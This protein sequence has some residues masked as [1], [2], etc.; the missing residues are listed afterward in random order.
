MHFLV[1]SLAPLEVLVNE[2][3]LG[4]PVSGGTG[5]GVRDLGAP[6]GQTVL[7]ARVELKG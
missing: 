6:E 3:P 2:L 5:L 7:C 1:E 4:E